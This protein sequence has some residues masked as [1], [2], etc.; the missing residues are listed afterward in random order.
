M[1]DCNLSYI[2]IVNEEKAGLN[3]TFNMICQMCGAKFQVKSSK[4]SESKM[5]I[6]EEVVAGIMSTGAGY[7]QLNT[8]LCHT[9][10]PPMSLRRYQS[11]HDKVCQ[12][13]EKTAP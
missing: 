8:V 6:N 4:A 13:W 10:I 3:S 2:K 1:F 9:N 5:D 11:T 7:T 12:W